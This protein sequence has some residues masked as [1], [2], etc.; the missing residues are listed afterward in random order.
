M[1]SCRRSPVVARLERSGDVHERFLQAAFTQ[2]AR[3][4]DDFDLRSLAN[5]VWALAVSGTHPERLLHTISS[6]AQAALKRQLP[7]LS[8]ESEAHSLIFSLLA[9]AWALKFHSSLSRDLESEIGDGLHRIAHFLER[10]GSCASVKPYMSSLIPSNLLEFPEQKP[11]I[12]VQPAGMLVALKPPGWEVDTTIA[13]SEALSLS[14]FLQSHLVAEESPLLFDFKYSYGFIHRLDVASSGL[15]LAARTH[16]GLICLQLQKALCAIDREYIVMCEGTGGLN[17]A[18]QRVVTVEVAT[19]GLNFDKN[20]RTLTQDSG[21]PAETRLRIVAHLS[22]NEGMSNVSLAAIQIYTGRR[23]Q[24]R[25]H[26]RFIG[27]P[28]VCDAWYAPSSVHLSMKD[29][30]GPPPARCWVRTPRWVGELPAPP[31]DMVNL[32]GTGFTTVE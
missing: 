19:R 23:H 20:S 25:A 7:E 28:T 22:C 29:M 6:A 2:V 13:E 17:S 10:R 32:V 8:S 16:H 5:L 24:I 30:L 31:Q 15:I 18:L 12:L 21:M 14:A 26:T 27:H 3:N 11:R 1:S 9:L 4:V